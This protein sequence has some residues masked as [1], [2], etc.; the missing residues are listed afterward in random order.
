MTG[1]AEKLV[2]LRVEKRETG[3]VA[4]V[5]VNN[6]GKRNALGI[7]GK[8]QLAKTF[9]ALTKDRDLR[10]AVLTGA[11]ERSF[12]AGAIL[13]R[14]TANL[15]AWVHDTQSIKPGVIMPSF[16]DTLTPEQVSDIVAY[17]NT[18]Q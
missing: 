3:H 4:Y 11:G 10:V 7:A 1:L 16:R 13:P 9:G 18:L 12:I 15:E 6:P 5:T 2:L 8:Q 17:L 14:T